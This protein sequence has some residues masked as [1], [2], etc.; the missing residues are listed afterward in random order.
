MRRAGDSQVKWRKGEPT[1]PGVGGQAPV[2]RRGV[3]RETGRRQEDALRSSGARAEG[4]RTR[5]AKDGE[6]GEDT[7]TDKGRTVSEA[8]IPV[9]FLGIYYRNLDLYS[10]SSKSSGLQNGNLK[11]NNDQNSPVEC[12]CSSIHLEEK[13]VHTQGQTAK[14]GAQNKRTFPTM[15]SRASRLGTHPPPSKIPSE[16]RTPM[17]Y[18][19]A[20]ASS[21]P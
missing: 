14:V 1:L 21:S 2:G 8:S 15:P 9:L 16:W 12:D 13:D 20:G 7:Y 5:E 17:Q 3:K 6:G 11:V 10:K 4:E 19:E 18:Q